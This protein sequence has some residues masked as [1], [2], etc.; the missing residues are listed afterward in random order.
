LES[1]VLNIDGNEIEKKLQSAQQELI[2]LQDSVQTKELIIQDLMKIQ[3]DHQGNVIGQ[4]ELDQKILD[5]LEST[6]R[7]LKNYEVCQLE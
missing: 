3:R 1:F 5:E 7:L 6:K 4:S 2:K